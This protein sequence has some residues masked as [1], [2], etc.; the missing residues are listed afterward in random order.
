M[1]ISTDYDYFLHSSATSFFRRMHGSVVDCIGVNVCCNGCRYFKDDIGTLSFFVRP[2]S[3]HCFAN[4]ARSW[5]ASLD[6]FP[7]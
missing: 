7:S 2:A 3:D 1:V 6:L 5:K 4:S